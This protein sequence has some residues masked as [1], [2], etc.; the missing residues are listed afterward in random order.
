MDTELLPVFVVFFFLSVPHSQ[1]R[2]LN[3]MTI[4]QDLRMYYQVFTT[5]RKLDIICRVLKH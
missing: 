1:V 4:F 2:L 5:N 3:L